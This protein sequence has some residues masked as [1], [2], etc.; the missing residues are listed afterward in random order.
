MSSDDS[1]E[2]TLKIKIPGYDGIGR[3]RFAMG[4]GA[5][6]ATYCGIPE[7]NDVSLE[8]LDNIDVGWSE[9]TVRFATARKAVL[10]KLRFSDELN[11]I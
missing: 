4:V 3:V 8:G 7:D 6:L 10:F 1:V 5:Y 2:R 9:I 11:F